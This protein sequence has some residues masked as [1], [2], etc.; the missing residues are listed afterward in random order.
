MKSILVLEG[1]NC[2][3]CAE[4]IENRVRKIDKIENVEFDFMS[5]KLCFESFNASEKDRIKA[6]I[7]K[8]VKNAEPDVEVV[9]KN[10]LKEY[11]L[12]LEGLD[13]ANCAG[14]IEDRIKGL[15][16]VENVSVDF[17]STTCKYECDVI[18][19][20]QVEEEIIN[21]IHEIEPDVNVRM[22]KNE[23]VTTKKDN[24]DIVQ[25]A[26]GTILL[27]IGIL[28]EGYEFISIIFT[29]TAYLV[30]GYSILLRAFKNIIKG[31]IFDE[32]FLMSLATL[33]A[34][35]L[36]EYK[37]AVAVMLFYQVG[38][39]FQERAVFSSR[40]S[41]ADLMDIRPDV[42]TVIKDGIE[43]VIAAED[44]KI[45]DMLLIKPGERIPLDGIIHKGASSLD[46]SSLTGESLERDVEVGDEVLSG[47]VNRSGVLE[48]KV[49]KE[50]KDSTVSKI[51]ELVENTSSKKAKSE[52]FIT[53]FAKVYTPIVVLLAAALAIGLPLFDSSV[54]MYDSLYRASTFLV[55]SCPCALVISIPLGFFAGIGGL[56]KNGILVKG[57]TVI[58][59]LSSLKQIVF[60]KT[61]TLTKGEFGVSKIIGNNECLELAAYAESNSTHP[62]AVSIVKAYGKNIDKSKIDA[63]EELAGHGIKIKL[64]NDIVLVG[65]IKLMQQNNVDVPVIDEIGTLVYVA[66][67]G[68]YIGAI[69]ILD[70][71]KEDSK[72]AI[73][74][75][76]AIGIS[77]CT[78]VTGDAK[79]V[80]MKI[81]DEVKIDHVYSECLPQQKVEVVEQLLPNGKLGFVG[82]GIND[83]PVLALAD[84]GFAMGGVG[85]DAA[86]EAAD[87]VIMDDHLT[88]VALAISKSK[89]TMRIVHQNIVGAIGIKIVVL[90]LGALGIAN[91]WLA[92]FADVGVSVLAILNSIRLL[93]K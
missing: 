72:E 78:M 58:E 44:I 74:N 45:G 60:D 35:F 36:G 33:C 92:I 40:Q 63:N 77:D 14:K 84:I 91:M 51:L 2:A 53:K 65:N 41:I 30:L 18:D 25:I 90:I 82:D 6:E 85:S 32:N 22:K 9:E 7:V 3:H 55:I 54:T 21:I 68:T 50:F 42:G 88:K 59:T 52:Q 26:I 38:E 24:K 69:V 61:G 34:L 16:N 86:I 39:S 31:K 62:I 49:T 4:K 23:K 17:M 57:S 8:I 66:K 56:S 64:I 67:N 11:E 71:I 10:D 80:A 46:T 47:C 43:K 20:K 28:T 89:K 29:I 48:I 75:L 93:R 79:S 37:E 15:K 5:K 1:L 81:A 87:V 13:C 70:Q 76:K 27:L 19:H 73:K 83:A 12:F